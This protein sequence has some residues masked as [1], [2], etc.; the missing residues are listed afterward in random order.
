MFESSNFNAFC[1]SV[2]CFGSSNFDVI[3]FWMSDVKF[4]VIL[5]GSV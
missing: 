5:D 1:F 3:W 2:K 4:F